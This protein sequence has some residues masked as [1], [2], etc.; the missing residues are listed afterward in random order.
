MQGRAVGV[1]V[2][3]H[4]N[5]MLLHPR[6]QGSLIGIH[7]RKRFLAL[8]RFAFAAHRK[9]NLKSFFDR[10]GKK[11]LLPA[12]LPHLPSKVLVGAIVGTKCITMR[13]ACIQ[14]E[15][16]KSCGFWHQLGAYFSAKT[17]S[18]QEVPITVHQVELKALLTALPQP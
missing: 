3:Q 4:R 1:P 15:G 8:G 18:D 5:M 6:M 9:G 14:S 12:C 13:Q 16:M 17:A 2:N 7:D 11:I 10:L